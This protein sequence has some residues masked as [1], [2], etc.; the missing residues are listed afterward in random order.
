[1][2]IIFLIHDGISYSIAP[3]VKTYHPGCASEKWPS[4]PI[5]IFLGTGNS[6]L[7]TEDGDHWPG[8]GPLQPIKDDFITE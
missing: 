2:P 4:I 7:M 8:K 5:R 1:M 6:R 3:P